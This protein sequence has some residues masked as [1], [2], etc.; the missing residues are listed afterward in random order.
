MAGNRRL[1]PMPT[2]RAAALPVFENEYAPAAPG[3]V[4]TAAPRRAHWSD[5]LAAKIRSTPPWVLFL[6]LAATAVIYAYVGKLILFIIAAV[7]FVRGWIW[8]SWRFPMTMIFVNTF[9]S[10][11]MSNGRRR[12]W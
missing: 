3:E 9:I 2:R 1:V 4:V 6:W 12:R 5:N 8:L 11:L 7:L 10:A